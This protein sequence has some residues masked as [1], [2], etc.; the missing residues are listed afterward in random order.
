MVEFE[1]RAP[2]VREPRVLG[3]VK[4]LRPDSQLRRRAQH[5]RK[6]ARVVGRG[7]QEQRLRLLRQPT[8][9]REEGTLDAGAD[10][11]G[12]EQRLAAA[13]LCL[14]QRKWKLEQGERVPARSLDEPLPSFS[15]KRDVS[16]AIE[17]RS[18]RHRI[19]PAELE[20]GEP[21]RLEPTNLSFAGGE[22]HHDPLRLQPPGNEGE[23]VRRS[24][25]EPLRIIDQAEKRAPLG[26]L[27][28]QAQDRQGNEKAVVARSRASSSR[29]DLPT[30]ASPR[31]TSTPLRD[32]RAPSKSAP[33]RERSASLP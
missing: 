33:M 30:P 32:S 25:V 22:E 23:R 15:R 24:V 1:L 2:C 14:A 19:K 27:R 11:Q 13:K 29:A 16:M 6:L 26:R 5:G 3:R 9:A 4:R 7:D 31:I 20:L 10:R 18:R 28:Q 21:G 8:H 12:R 17:Q